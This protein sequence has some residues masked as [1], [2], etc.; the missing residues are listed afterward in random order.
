MS[1][2]LMRKLEITIQG[3][4]VQAFMRGPDMTAAQGHKIWSVSALVYVDWQSQ[5]IAVAA[6]LSGDP[7]MIEHYRTG[8]FYMAFGKGAGLVPETATKANHAPFRNKVLKPVSLGALYG[9]KEVGMAARIKRF[10]AGR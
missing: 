6:Y 10:D 4:L 9:Q 8:D 1:P 3:Q 7:L 2:T 5:E